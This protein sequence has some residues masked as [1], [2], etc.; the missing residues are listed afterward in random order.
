MT[1][2]TPRVSNNF[3]IITTSTMIMPTHFLGFYVLVGKSIS[4]A[5]AI[6]PQLKQVEPINENRG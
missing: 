1:R 6:Y 3:F 4:P 2:D 5:Q